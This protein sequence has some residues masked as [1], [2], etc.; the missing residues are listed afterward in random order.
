MK[1][2]LPPDPATYPEGKR[3]LYRVYSGPPWPGE[4]H[5][6]RVSDDRVM[7]SG[8]LHAMCQWA[9]RRERVGG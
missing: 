5:V 6:V 1:Y 8:S 7:K 4:W 9:A 3:P 2:K